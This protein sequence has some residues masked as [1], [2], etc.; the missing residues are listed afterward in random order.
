[1][2]QDSSPLTSRPYQ[3]FIGICRPT[4]TFRGAIL[5]IYFLYKLKK[6]KKCLPYVTLKVHTPYDAIPFNSS[7]HYF[8]NN[9]LGKSTPYIS[10]IIATDV[11]TRGRHHNLYART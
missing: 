9:A 4:V 7:S 3:V 6:K 5:F 11:E 2:Y 8:F 10:E 1:M